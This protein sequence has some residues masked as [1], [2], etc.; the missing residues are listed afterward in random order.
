[1][2]LYHYCGVETFLNI[3]RFHTLRLSDLCKST[4]SLELKS[5][6]EAVE[7]EVAE[8]YRTNNDFLESVI[9]G[10]NM[11]DAFFFILKMVMTK[12]K[13]N[14]DQMLFGVCFSEEGDLLDQ[15]RKYTDKGTGLAIGFD[16]G[17]FQELCKNDD[18][19]FSKVTYGYK[20]ENEDIVKKYAISIYNEMLTAIVEGRTKNIVEGLYGASFIMELDRKCIYQD[21]VFIKKEEYRN[22]KEWRF[23]LNDEGTY[24]SRDDWDVYYNWKR[25]DFNKSNDRLQKLI[26]NGMEFLA[27]NGKIIPYLD[28]KFDLDEDNLPI[29]KIVI[30]PNCKV[31]ELDI[32]HLLEFFGFD[33]DEIE[34]I[35]SKSSYCL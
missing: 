6:M 18:F 35:K 27:R 8:Q 15:W 34:I 12:M 33:G 10:M 25:S 32:Y 13:K 4:D 23:I 26:P 30:G 29:K 11:D 20:K 31:E 22:E 14:S 19:R 24:K 28:L 2:I 3:I 21:S 17:W 16:A 5:L 1:M 9:Y 7:K